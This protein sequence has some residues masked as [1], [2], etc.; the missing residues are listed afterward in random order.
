M[1]MSREIIIRAYEAVKGFCEP[2]CLSNL[3]APHR[4]VRH[5]PCREVPVAVT[6]LR[7]CA[8]GAAS[9]ETPGATAEPSPAD[10]AAESPPK[11]SGRRHEKKRPGLSAPANHQRRIEEEKHHEDVGAYDMFTLCGCQGIS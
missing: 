7:T 10:D 4:T 8:R 3:I 9:A 11:P 6:E 2:D 1:K 5:F